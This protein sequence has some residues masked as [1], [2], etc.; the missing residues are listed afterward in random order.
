MIYFDILYYIFSFVAPLLLLS[1]LNTRLTLAY[2]K[3][4]AN[5]ARMNL[6]TDQDN[7]ITLVMIIVVLVFILCQAPARIVQMI[8]SYQSH[9][10]DDYRFYLTE[11]SKF[12]EVLNSSVNFFIYCAFRKQFRITLRETFCGQYRAVPGR[13]GVVMDGSVQPAQNKQQMIEETKC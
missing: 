11:L 10:C 5:R 6:R 7:N 9:V 4:Q 8:W 13:N 1:F 12:L 3:I 2:R